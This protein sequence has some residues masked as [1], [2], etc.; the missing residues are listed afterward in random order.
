MK[1]GTG[2]KVLNIVKWIF[3]VVIGIFIVL[4]ILV[5]CLQRFSNNELAFFD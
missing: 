5:V 3:N 2:K 4:F 1:K